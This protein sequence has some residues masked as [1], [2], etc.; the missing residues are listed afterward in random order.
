[1]FYGIL[2]NPSTMLELIKLAWLPDNEQAKEIRKNE[3][4]KNKNLSSIAKIALE[5]LHGLEAQ[6]CENNN[7]V[8]NGQDLKKYAK[9]L[10]EAA[11]SEY[12]ERPAMYV[13]GKL[14][15]NINLGEDYPPHYL[16]EIL[17][18]LDKD[19]IDDEYRRQLFNRHGFTCRAYNEGG[20]IERKREKKFLSY[21][22]KTR[23]TYDRITIVFE[24]LASEYHHMG[25]R[26]DVNAKLEDLD[27]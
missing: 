16:G 3:F 19:E 14:L 12:L 11:K 13:I 18:E 15:G 17:E 4:A 1:M 10:L 2:H 24:K 7:G 26:E 21:A 6:P 20:T 8:V 27:N 5:I 9:E 25:D 22:E 23:F